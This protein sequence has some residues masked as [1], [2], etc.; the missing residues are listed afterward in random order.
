MRVIFLDF[1]GV[2]HPVSALSW[3]QLRRPLR[4]TIQ[5]ARLFRWTWVLDEL[6]VGHED[7]QLLVHSTWRLLQDEQTLHEVL[8]PLAP[9][10]AGRTVGADRYQS[11]VD[12]LERLPGSQY[13]I[14]DDHAEQFPH[15]VEHLIVCDPELGVYD[16]RVRSRLRDWLA[17]TRP[18]AAP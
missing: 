9:R 1:D 11:I 6:L 3:F 7:V 10:F 5:M 12:A 2:L 8:G 18:G 15:E 14:L 16:E 13:Q 4:Q 17:Q